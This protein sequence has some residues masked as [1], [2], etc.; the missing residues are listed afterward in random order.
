MTYT[1]RAFNAGT[2]WVPGPEVGHPRSS[3]P[4]AL[5]LVRAMVVNVA[6]EE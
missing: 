5:R 4:G 3:G 2:F 1:I 6:A